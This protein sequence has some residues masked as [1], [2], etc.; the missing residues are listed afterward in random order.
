MTRYS[1]FTGISREPIDLQIM[2]CGIEER[3]RNALVKGN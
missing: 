2:F 1:L 3:E